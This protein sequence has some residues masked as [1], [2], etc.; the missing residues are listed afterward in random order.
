MA[1]S[2]TCSSSRVGSGHYYSISVCC[3]LCLS[4]LPLSCLSAVTEQIKRTIND[5]SMFCMFNTCRS[6]SSLLLSIGA[7]TA[8]SN[9]A[10]VRD[11]FLVLNLFT[12]LLL[13]RSDEM[14]ERGALDR[15]IYQICCGAIDPRVW[16]CSSQ[17][18]VR[19]F[20]LNEAESNQPSN[21]LTQFD[22]SFHQL[23]TWPHKL[24][25]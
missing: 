4:V 14:T 7:A 9:L 12:F 8:C 18:S 16:K 20:L 17:I 24:F 11:Y 21:S 22:F 2:F 15:S 25:F 5:Q 19:L 13:D 1:D 6:V 3:L 23:A 10:V